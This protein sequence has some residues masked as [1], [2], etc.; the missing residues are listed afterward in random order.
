MRPQ[1]DPLDPSLY[2]NFRDPDP[3][4]SLACYVLLQAVRDWRAL[5]ARLILRPDDPEASQ[6]L[7]RLERN[8]RRGLCAAWLILLSDTLA[9]ADLLRLL[10]R[11]W[12]ERLAEGP[13]PETWLYQTG[14]PF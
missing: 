13:D 10:R 4:K 8:F 6:A 2:M 11:D 9:G 1:N 12:E 14:L 5:K 3:L 7:A